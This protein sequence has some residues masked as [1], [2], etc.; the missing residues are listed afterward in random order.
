[1]EVL[2]F[3]NAV[4]VAI[5][6]FY[7]PPGRILASSYAHVHSAELLYVRAAGLPALPS[8]LCGGRKSYISRVSGSYPRPA[9]ARRTW[10]VAH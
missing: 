7:N 4:K 9:N 1:M 3:E 8:W 6:L 2:R 5:G 10:A